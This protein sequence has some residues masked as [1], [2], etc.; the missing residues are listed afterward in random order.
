MI[1]KSVVSVASKCIRKR[2]SD[3]RSRDSGEIKAVKF[4]VLHSESHF[5]PKG[6]KR[7]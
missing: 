7:I 6:R 5:A 2:M 1:W 3:E 4:S